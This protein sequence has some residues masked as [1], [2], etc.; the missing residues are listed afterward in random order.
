MIRVSQALSYKSLT[1]HHI[2]RCG[3]QMQEDLKKWRA[4]CSAA[5]RFLCSLGHMTLALF[6][7]EEAIEIMEQEDA[8]IHRHGNIGWVL[9]GGQH[10]Q[11]DKHDVVRRVAEAIIRRAE[12][13]QGG[14]EKA[15][16]DGQDAEAEVRR[17]E[18]RQQP[19]EQG[20]HRSGG[21]HEQGHVAAGQ[22]ADGHG[23]ARLVRRVAPP[24]H[25]GPD[26]HGQAHA[27]IGEH[28]APVAEAAGDGA[29]E[30]AEHDHEI[31]REDLPLGREHQG[32]HAGQGGDQRQRVNVAAEKVGH[33]HNGQRT[34]PERPV[35][36]PH[37]SKRVI[38]IQRSIL[39]V[40]IR[41]NR[42]SGPRVR[43]RDASAVQG[44]RFSPGKSG[45]I[46][47]AAW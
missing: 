29:V 28:L 1:H 3:R 2:T 44:H 5:R 9:A 7:A 18:R 12:H 21:Q 43:D 13:G 33:G 4:A 24:R 39:S 47:A 26:R 17:I 36:G 22:A 23:A 34:E 30:Q 41:S 31:L 11:H 25:G 42:V 37:G 38:H 19:T 16:G 45:R 35:S 40:V 46:T 14:R 32:R 27:E 8:E 15:R 20:R 10:P 6:P